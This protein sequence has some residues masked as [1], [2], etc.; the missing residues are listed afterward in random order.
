MF[1]ASMGSATARAMRPPRSIWI[2]LMGPTGWGGDSLSAFLPS[3]SLLDFAPCPC[4]AS[5]ARAAGASSEPLLASSDFGATGE[6][7]SR[8]SGSA[9][10]PPDFTIAKSNSTSDPTG[11]SWRLDAKYRYFPSDD[12]AGFQSIPLPSPRRVSLSVASSYRTRSRLRP[13]ADR[14][15]ASQRPSGENA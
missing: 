15:N 12:H 3:S 4:L 5:F 11:F 8:A 1:A 13:T 10:I 6:P 2:G 9:Y 14:L 7:V